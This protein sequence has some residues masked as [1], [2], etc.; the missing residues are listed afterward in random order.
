MQPMDRQRLDQQVPT[1]LHAA[2]IA[3]KPESADPVTRDLARRVAELERIVEG[4]QQQLDAL[5]SLA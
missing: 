2:D 3:Q 1:A 5:R 4:L